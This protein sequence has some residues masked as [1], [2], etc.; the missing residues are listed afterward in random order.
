VK[1][2]IFAKSFNRET[3]G[4]DLITVEALMRLAAGL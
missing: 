1:Y 3:R 2:A 4:A